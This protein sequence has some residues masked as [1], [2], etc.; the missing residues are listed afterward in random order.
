MK[1]KFCEI[2][3]NVDKW[4]LRRCCLKTFLIYNSGSPFVLRFRPICAILVKGTIEED[5]VQLF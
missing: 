1:K 2:I 5:S 3:L 4:F